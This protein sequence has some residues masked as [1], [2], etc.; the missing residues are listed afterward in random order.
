MNNDFWT[1][2]LACYGHEGVAQSC[3]ALQDDRG[4]DVNVILYAAWLASMNKVLSESHLAALEVAVAPWQQRVVAPLR[5]QRRAL[6]GYGEAAKI[7]QS[8]KVLELEAERQQ[9]DMMWSFFLGSDDVADSPAPL[10]SNLAL[11]WRSDHSQCPEFA[12]LFEKLRQSQ[13]HSQR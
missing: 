12:I 1:F 5:A 9:Q 4:L 7:R 2:S 3:L 11:L 6:R 13:A 8:L 10:Q